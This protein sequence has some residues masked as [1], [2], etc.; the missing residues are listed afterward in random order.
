MNNEEIDEFKALLM[1]SKEYSGIRFK[2]F[3]DEP[4][5]ETELLC[6][7]SEEQ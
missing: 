6:W 4:K 1:Y 7:I 3:E 2:D 5:E